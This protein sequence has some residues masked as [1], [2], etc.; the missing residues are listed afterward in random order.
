MPIFS[1][2]KRLLVIVFFLIIFAIFLNYNQVLASTAGEL[3][4]KSLNVTAQ[5]TGHKQIPITAENF[6]GTVGRIIGVAISF[7]GV[8]FLLLMIYGGFRW[9][10]AHGNEQEIEK[11]KGIIQTAIVGL[12]IVLLAY[13]L[14]K[15]FYSYFGE[16]LIQGSNEGY[17]GY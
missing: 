13:I 14:T 9:M 8:I 1:L 17:Q 11:A 2:H 15:T 6:P 3:F 12:V 4:N 7:L 10:M 5:E 16:K